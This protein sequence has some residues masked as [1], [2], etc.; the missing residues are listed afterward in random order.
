[1]TIRRRDNTRC[2]TRMLLKN[3]YVTIVYYY[4]VEERGFDETKEEDK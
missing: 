2:T 3:C 4:D 1:M